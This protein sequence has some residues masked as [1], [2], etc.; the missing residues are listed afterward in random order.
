MQ[1]GAQ[2]VPIHW[3][4]VENANHTNPKIMRLLRRTGL[5]YSYLFYAEKRIYNTFKAGGVRNKGTDF[6]RNL[7]AHP[8]SVIYFAGKSLLV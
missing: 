8:D 4:V 1:L 5:S 6:V 3:I 7:P 2:H